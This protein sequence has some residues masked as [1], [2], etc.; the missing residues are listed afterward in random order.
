MTRPCGQ[1][2]GNPG[3]LRVR[4]HSRPW[5]ATGFF[6]H[7]VG[8]IYCHSEFSDMDEFND[9][10]PE[11]IDNDEK[12]L[13]IPDARELDLGKPLAVDFARQVLPEDVDEVRRI[14]SRKGAYASFK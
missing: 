5:R 11:D 2:P 8:Q 1:L 6:V 9:E 14:F 4:Q 10:L 13:A 7:T 3:R 12:Y